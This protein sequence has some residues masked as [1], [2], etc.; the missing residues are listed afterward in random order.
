[1]PSSVAIQRAHLLLSQRRYPEAERELCQA[2]SADPRDAHAHALLSEALLQQ[3]RY[4]DAEREAQQ[5]IGLAP[6][7]ALGH[8]ALASVLRERRRY[9]D[10][11]RAVA[12]AIQLDPFSPYQF[13]MLAQIR[14]EQRAWREALD[15]AE[16]GLAI[17]PEDSACLN[18]RAMA[19]VK[20]GRRQEAARTID[21]ALANDPES[22]VTHAN[23]GWALLHDGEAHRALEHFREA[24][25][26]DPTN[27]WARAG[28]V[29]AMKARNIVYRWLLRYFL[30]MARLSGRAQAG[31]LFGGWIG[32]RLLRQAARDNPQLAPYVWPLIIAYICFALL[33]WLAA[34]LFNLILRLDRFGRHALTREQTLTSNWML[35]LLLAAAGA[36]AA[37]LV[38]GTSWLPILAL[39]A[40][41]LALP[42][43]TIWQCDEGWPRWTNIGVVAALGLLA[44]L[45]VVLDATAGQ[46]A[47]GA[48]F[49]LFLVGTLAASFG[50]QYLA[51]ARPKR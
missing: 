49:G 20:L 40:L 2:L 12:H 48:P 22:A 14:F 41:L 15:A 17:D 34:P 46:K 25:R 30:F 42:V 8:A 35:G 5:A 13:A 21:G 37:A 6:D 18:L 51:A 7:E 28:I 11:A 43:S 26:L 24:V 3:H 44:A 16:R 47:S 31:I 4:D 36:G 33:T 9:D 1:M 23:Q 27:E 38:W 19:L 10:A 45:A 50:V 39:C 32:F 29:E